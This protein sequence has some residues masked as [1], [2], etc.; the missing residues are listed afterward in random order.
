MVKVHTL[1]KRK[2]RIR[3]HLNGQ[4]LFSKQNHDRP[5]VFKTEEAAR[6][7]AQNQKMPKFKIVNVA[8]SPDKQKFKIHTRF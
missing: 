8:T 5:K 4:K 2:Y 3:T 6:S 1:R 7:Y